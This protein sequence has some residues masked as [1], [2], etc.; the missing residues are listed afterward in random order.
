MG[1]ADDLRATA[2]KMQTPAKVL[3]FDIETRHAIYAS[4]GPKVRG[5]WMGKG[6]QLIRSSTMF[7]AA[8]WYH[9]SR[10]L[11]ESIAH[12]DVMFLKPEDT[13][14][15]AGM[16]ESLRDLLDKADIVSTYNGDRFDIPRVRG[17]FKRLGLRQPLP[18]ASL[19]LI[20]TIRTMGFDYNS[21]QEAAEA[22]GLGGKVQHQGE[23][24]WLDCL[25]GDE[26]AW[27]VMTKYGRRDVVLTEQVA[28]AYRPEIKGHPNLNLWSFD[29]QGNPVECCVN[30]GHTEFVPVAKGKVTP[31]TRYGTMECAA[32]H[33]PMRRSY[34][35]AR[36]TIRSAR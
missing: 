1:L 4:F 13:P 11:S 9:E 8:K 24:L 20:K 19:D 14:G 15:Y 17:E 16:M 12:E 21:L 6:K 31:Q 32:C 22:V 27:R 23:S 3:T 35:K 10:V 7:W 28:D 2:H 33:A 29:A 5:G 36:T 30:C 18:F 25:R 26:K 34:V